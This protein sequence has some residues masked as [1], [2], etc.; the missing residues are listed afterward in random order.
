MR[1]LF[2]LVFFSF[3]LSRSALFL[4]PFLTLKYERSD[5]DENSVSLVKFSTAVDTRYCEINLAS[6]AAAAGQH[7]QQQWR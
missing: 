7:R 3:S 4:V 6:A 2:V 1:L 5:D